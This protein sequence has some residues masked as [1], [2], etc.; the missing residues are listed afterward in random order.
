ME[1][2]I[3]RSKDD[4]D[5]VFICLPF[6]LWIGVGQYVTREFVII[7][8]GTAFLQQFCASAVNAVVSPFILYDLAM[9]AAKFLS[10]NNPVH[11]SSQLRSNILNPLYQKCL[12]M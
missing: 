4:D 7:V 10:R 5:N 9:D 6:L 12:Q 8:S 3:E 2:W 1:D 11:L